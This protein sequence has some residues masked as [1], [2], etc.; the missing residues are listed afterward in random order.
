MAEHTGISKSTVQRW[1]D[2][3]GVQPHRQRHFKLS[4]DPF[5]IEKVRDIVGLY[6][7]PPDHA[8]AGAATAIPPT[9]ASWINQVERWFGLITQQ[10][11][12]TCATSSGCTRLP[13]DTGYITRLLDQSGRALVRAYHPTGD[14]PRLVLQR[15]GTDPQ[16]QRLRRTIQCTSQPVHLGRYRRVNPCQN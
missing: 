16:N 4:N 6:L 11:N 9:Y 1:F 14:P 15:Q 13:C 8:V 2:R 7:N 10:A 5:F 3:F 12:D